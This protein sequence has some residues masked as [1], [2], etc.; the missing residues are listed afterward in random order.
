MISDLAK[1]A[2][3]VGLQMHMGKTKIL[4]NMA[5]LSGGRL[6]VR[7]AAIEI[8]PASAS[9][10]YLGRSL[11]FQDF[12]NVELEA[13][14]DKAWKKFFGYRRELCDRSVAFKTRIRLLESCVASTLLYGSGAWV[15]TA[16]RERRL[17]T[18][19]RRMLR[20]MLGAFRRVQEHRVPSEGDEESLS[21]ESHA[22]TPPD[23]PEDD[24]EDWTTWIKRVTHV[25]DS[26]L[27]AVISDDWV[28]A[29][30]RRKWRLAGH[31]ARRDDGRWATRVAEWEPQAGYRD[32]GHPKKRWTDELDAFLKYKWGA[33][34]KFWLAA[35]QDRDAWKRLENEFVHSP[36]FSRN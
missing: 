9:T 6:L 4:T 21:D 30:R 8:L 1:E 5:R 19:Q 35:A 2:E 17:R 13:R 27:H 26:C 23:E 14:L 11:C 22:E 24:E 33:P 34:K 28:T 32:R 25:V 31:I 7:D 29:Q 16:E 12:H 36:W 15:M 20:W 3:Q 18:T 10:D